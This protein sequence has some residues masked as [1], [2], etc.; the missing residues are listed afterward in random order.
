MSTA[1][2]YPP[3]HQFQYPPTSEFHANN[4]NYDENNNSPHWNNFN[5]QPSIPEE[6]PRNLQQSPVESTAL[7]KKNEA[8]KK[9]IEKNNNYYLSEFRVNQCQLFLQHKCNNH[10]PFTCFHWHFKNQRRRQSKILDNG[11]FNYSPDIYCTDYNE[12]TGECPKGDSCPYLHRNT[13]DT[14][15]RYHLRYFK[16]SVCIHE[17]DESTGYCAKNGEHC[18][19]A[20][21]NDLRQPI[22]PDSGN[23]SFS[24]GVH[25]LS[26]NPSSEG[27][28]SMDSVSP[29]NIEMPIQKP[30]T[31]EE[32]T[33]EICREK[34]IP[35]DPRWDNAKFVLQFYKTQPC[36]KPPRLCRQGYACPFFHNNRDKRRSPKTH[37]YKST[38]CPNV[39]VGSDWKDPA[40][41]IAKDDCDYCHTRTEQQ[42]HPDIYKSNRCNDMQQTGY[43]PR[44]AFCAFAHVQNNAKGVGLVVPPKTS[45]VP[46]FEKQ[47]IKSSGRNRV[48]S[49]PNMVILKDFK[50]LQEG[51]KGAN[52]AIGSH[53]NS[54]F[55]R[56]VQEP[57][58]EKSYK[59]RQMTISESVSP[60]APIGDR[61]TS[62][63]WDVFRKP[64]SPVGNTIFGR[65]NK[66]IRDRNT[67]SLGIIDPSGHRNK[68]SIAD[69]IKDIRRNRN[70]IN[71]HQTSA[72]IS[73]E[74]NVFKGEF[75]RA[76]GLSKFGL[77]PPSIFETK[78][79]PSSFIEADFG[80]SMSLDKN[81]D[82]GDMSR[83][84][85]MGM[86]V[87]AQSPKMMEGKNNFFENKISL[88][89]QD[90]NEKDHVI[91]NLKF[92][93]SLWEN[94]VGLDKELNEEKLKTMHRKTLQNLRNKLDQDRL[95]IE[96]L[97][98]DR[99]LF[100]PT[101]HESIDTQDYPLTSHNSENS[102]ATISNNNISQTM[103][104]QMFYQPAFASPSNSHFTGSNTKTETCCNHKMANSNASSQSNFSNFNMYTSQFG[105]E[106]RQPSN[107]SSPINF[108]GKQ[109]C[110]G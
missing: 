41:C 72:P 57:F 68:S 73:M 5:Q 60:W 83:S 14:E 103:N 23:D 62:P 8:E 10:R 47:Q 36:P 2:D 34:I 53:R 91:E 56:N 32:I 22:Y 65:D 74:R 67:C 102:T 63:K 58:A 42:F 51:N 64:P 59:P 6:G 48:I 3:K 28:Q 25:N 82:N 33:E 78:P 89:Q 71:E 86:P 87:V 46:Q 79:N 107:T 15:R 100:S 97:L 77:S 26:L 80:L 19:F 69:A 40:L 49:E 18:A 76:P 54:P 96:H 101:A 93:L 110:D 94:C 35:D 12:T 45:P 52:G 38:A 20:H 105:H 55:E 85:S 50:K 30:I 84:N 11:Q 66:T 17:T 31:Y 13:N 70:G 81:K 61:S 39:K 9:E 92:K 98:F 95:K 27:T 75:Q 99:K 104:Q 43:C 21:G 88:L 37:K 24:S 90:L 44:G 29:T 7:F 109:N 1:F 16:T 106:F 108:E 4:D